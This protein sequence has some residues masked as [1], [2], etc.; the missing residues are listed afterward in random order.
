MN[1]IKKQFPNGDR[2]MERHLP[3]PNPGIMSSSCIMTG[4]RSGPRLAPESDLAFSSS[5]LG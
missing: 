5:W 4:W 1:K 2:V 3:P